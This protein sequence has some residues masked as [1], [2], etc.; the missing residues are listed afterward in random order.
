MHIYRLRIDPYYIGVVGR[1]STEAEEA[2]GPKQHEAR[3]FSGFEM[4]IYMSFIFFPY[5]THFFLIVR[6]T[7]DFK[8]KPLDRIKSWFSG[9]IFKLRQYLLTV[10]VTL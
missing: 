7:T 6:S 2:E 5:Y 8:E 9:K 4:S 3:K 10:D 1:M